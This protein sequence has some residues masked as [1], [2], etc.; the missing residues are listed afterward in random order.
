VRISVDQVHDRRVELL[1]TVAVLHYAERI[2]PNIALAKYTHEPYG[3][4]ARHTVFFRILILFNL[5]FLLSGLVL[6]D[7]VMFVGCVV[8]CGY[9]ILYRPATWGALLLCNK[10]SV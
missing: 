6:V 2:H 9:A 1:G 3:I 4:L 7:R 10:S 8:F 5:T